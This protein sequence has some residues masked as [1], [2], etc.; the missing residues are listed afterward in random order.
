MYDKGDSEYIEYLEPRGQDEDLVIIYTRN[1]EKPFRELKIVS[2]VPRD[3]LESNFRKIG[4]NEKKRV[5]A[6]W[7]SAAQIIPDGFEL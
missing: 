2:A 4:P 5:L 1:G 6:V 3:F 7:S